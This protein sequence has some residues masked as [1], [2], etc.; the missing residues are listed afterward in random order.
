MRVLVV[1]DDQEMAQAVAVGLRRA[2]M[3][4]DVAY[5]G[6][7]GLERALLSDYDVIVLDRDLPG[8]HGDEIC[9]ELIT[10]G[11][12]SRVLML[13]AAASAEDLVDGLNLGA[14]DYLAKPFDF[15]VLVARIGALARRAHPA[16]PPVVRHGDLVVDTARRKATRAGRPLEL[17]P[18]EFGV[19]ELLLSA[20]GRAVSAEELLERVWDEAADPFTSAVKITISRLRAKLGDPPVIET[21]AKRG[22][23]I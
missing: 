15:P 18:K 11:C 13:T 14:D 4:V 2:Q 22:Y 16:V 20:K 19:L 9:S 23:R 17:A 12:R 3:A 21:V 8:V 7:S 10:S 6:E 1:E 5:D